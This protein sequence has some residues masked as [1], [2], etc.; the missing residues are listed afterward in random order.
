M[1]LLSIIKELYLLFQF[2]D[3]KIGFL[4]INS[5]THPKE[6]RKQ[7]LRHPGAKGSYPKRESST[8]K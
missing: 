7:F 5:I 3:G 4:P 8:P 2:V 1:K 6:E